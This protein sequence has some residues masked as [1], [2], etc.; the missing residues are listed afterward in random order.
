M[1]GGCF[2]A[3][4]AFPTHAP[5]NTRTQAGNE[6]PVETYIRNTGLMAEHAEAFGALLLYAEHRYYG[7]SEPLGGADS[8]RRDAR[9]LSSGQ[10]LADYAA[11]LSDRAAAWGAQ[12][13]AV[14]AFGGS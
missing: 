11:L 5:P 9:F 10:A 1:W 13:S 12:R 2:R 8:W 4:H 14:V 6:G 7:K 3:L